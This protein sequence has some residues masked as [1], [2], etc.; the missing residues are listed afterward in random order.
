MK[1]LQE[2]V[3]KFIDDFQ[4]SFLEFKKSVG[5]LSVEEIF[6][7]FDRLNTQAKKLEHMI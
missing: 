3:A 1:N 2:D 6:L 4:K 5:S 7:R